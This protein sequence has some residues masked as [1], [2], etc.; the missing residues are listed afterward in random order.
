MLVT[1]RVSNS[2]VQRMTGLLIVRP[3]TGSYDCINKI[4]VINTNAGISL[5]NVQWTSES[6]GTLFFPGPPCI[7]DSSKRAR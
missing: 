5:V 3:L 6:L 4:P 7:N 2:D 1:P